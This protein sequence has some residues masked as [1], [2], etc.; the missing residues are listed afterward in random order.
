[1]M[2]TPAPDAIT[3]RI[4]VTGPPLANRSCSRCSGTKFR[5]V[6]G[7]PVRWRALCDKWDGDTHGTLE[8]RYCGRLIDE[9]REL[10]CGDWMTD[11]ETWDESS[12]ASVPLAVC[13]DCGRLVRLV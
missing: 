1:M 4:P 13:M 7:S 10:H 6:L 5:A 8:S 3:I 11:G 2:S 12:P 9:K